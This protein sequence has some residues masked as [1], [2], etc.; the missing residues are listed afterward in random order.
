SAAVRALQHTSPTRGQRTT[1]SAALPR[2]MRAIG[3]AEPGGPEVLKLVELPVPQ[4]RPTEVLIRVA[5]A[6]LNRADILQRRGRYPPPPG[7]PSHPGLEVSGHVAAVGSAATRFRVGD[8]VCALLEGGGYAEY[9]A[10][11]ERQ[12]LTIPKGVTLDRKSTR[13]NSSHVKISY[14]VFC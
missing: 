12:V 1:V 2:Q 5:A 14:A 13:L 10:V 3:I 11:D 6:G 9:A 8:A 7:A 4:V